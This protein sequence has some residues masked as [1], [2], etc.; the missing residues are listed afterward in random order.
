[1]KTTQDAFTAIRGHVADGC[2]VLM[3]NSDTVRI[4]ASLQG[5]NLYVVTDT[6][7]KFHADAGHSA[8][9]VECLIYV[10]PSLEI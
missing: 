2:E 5:W 1:V 10:Y 8:H 6:G 4:Q 3:N 7:L 9:V